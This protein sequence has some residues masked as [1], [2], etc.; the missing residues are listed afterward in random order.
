VISL[1]RVTFLEGL[2][3]YRNVSFD[4]GDY[5][6]LLRNAILQLPQTVGFFEYFNPLGR[7]GHGSG[8]MNSFSSLF[9]E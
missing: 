1:T 9:L 7:D 4:F 3:N 2:E 8:N 6:S 5:A